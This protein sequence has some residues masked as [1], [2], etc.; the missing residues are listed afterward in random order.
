MEGHH[1]CA[2]TLRHQCPRRAVTSRCQIMRQRALYRSIP[3]IWRMRPADVILQQQRRCRIL[4]SVNSTTC[5]AVR[6]PEV[7]A[8]RKK[9]STS[10]RDD[11]GRFERFGVA[12]ADLSKLAD[13]APQD[14]YNSKSSVVSSA[15]QL[16]Q[17][18]DSSLSGGISESSAKMADR[19]SKLG[20]NKLPDREQV[21]T[22]CLERVHFASLMHLTSLMKLQ[23]VSL[24]YRPTRAVKI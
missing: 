22:G 3:V 21:Q 2:M 5:K 17:L 1:H 8:G 9:G 14:V 13:S 6:T 10:S 15:A 23:A 24:C 18:L 12:T 4:P 16:A 20:T 11:K 7:S 19:G